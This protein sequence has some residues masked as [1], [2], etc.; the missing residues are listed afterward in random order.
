MEKVPKLINNENAKQYELEAEGLKARIEYIIAKNNVIYLTH[1][2]VPSQLEG[3]GIGSTIVKLA[4]EDIKSRE[5]QLMP[6][7][8]FVAAYI[9][10]HEEWN[11]IL[12]KGVK[13]K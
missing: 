10:R 13:L 11:E 9:K 2:E 8:P 1:T 7:C 3:K 5:M 12:M 4:L 6:L